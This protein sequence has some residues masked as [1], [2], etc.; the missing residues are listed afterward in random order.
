MPTEAVAL[1]AHRVGLSDDHAVHAALPAMAALSVR[2][3]FEV[4]RFDHENHPRVQPLVRD[5]AV[6][7]GQV[8]G[9]V[10]GS[11]VNEGVQGRAQPAR[12]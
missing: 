8:G 3:L 6:G 10:A 12:A 5:E 7:A 1:D 4:D 9:W 11:F 2:V